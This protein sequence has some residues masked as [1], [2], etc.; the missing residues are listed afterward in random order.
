M[1]TS[2]GELTFLELQ[3]AVLKN[4]F[5]EGDRADAKNWLNFRYEWIFTLEQWT[6]RK[7]Q[8]AL[9]ITG[10]TATATAPTAFG[11]AIQV[12]LA[13]GATLDP[14][15]WALFNQAFFGTN[16]SQSTP[17]AFTVINGQIYL[18]PTPSASETGRI[19]YLYDLCHKNSAGAVIAGPMTLNDDVPMIPAGHHL[20]LVHGSKGSGF[21]LTNVPMASQLEQDF[22][23]AITAMRA[24]YLDDLRAPLGSMPVDPIAYL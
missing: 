7:A 21:K 5:A 12:Q 17:R 24:N 23:N 2:S 14:M 20:S 4:G 3:E 6:F 19:L 11:T 9:T 22:S 1:P 10:G 8:A 15:D 13:S 16:V 18:G